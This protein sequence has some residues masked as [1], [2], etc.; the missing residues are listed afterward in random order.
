MSEIKPI[1]NNLVKEDLKGQTDTKFYYL[2]YKI[3]S[4]KNLKLKTEWKKKRIFIN[5]M[6][7]TVFFVEN[8]MLSE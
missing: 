3:C 2:N 4:N 5:F 7:K 6:C 8:G 1:G